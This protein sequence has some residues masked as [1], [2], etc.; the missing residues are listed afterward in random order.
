MSYEIS[1]KCP[2]CKTEMSYTRQLCGK[3]H[4][5]NELLNLDDDE[6]EEEN[7]DSYSVS[8]EETVDGNISCFEEETISTTETT[9]KRKYLDLDSIDSVVSEIEDVNKQFKENKIHR[10]IYGAIISDKCNNIVN[11]INNVKD[12]LEPENTED[13][14]YKTLVTEKCKQIHLII[15][16][17]RDKI[18]EI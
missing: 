10:L 2:I 15:K 12:N 6:D 3:T 13:I 17:L 8:S 18:P 9:R 16:E 14:E 1:N 11:K 4:C 5:S 7:D